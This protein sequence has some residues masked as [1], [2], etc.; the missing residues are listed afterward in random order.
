MDKKLDVV[1]N[2][3]ETTSEIFLHRLYEGLAKDF[4]VTCHYISGNAKKNDYSFSVQKIPKPKSILF[5]LFLILEILQFKKIKSLKESYSKF[6][7]SRFTSNK[8]YFPFISMLKYHELHLCS[9][10]ETK[11]IYTSVRGTDITVT[12]FINEEIISVYKKLTPFI[13]KIHFLSPELKNVTE[14]M[15]IVVKKSAIILQG[16]DLNEFKRKNELPQDSLRLITIGRLHY[17]KGLEFCLLV[18]S[19]L[20]RKGIPFLI[21]IVGNGSEHIKLK[22]ITKHLK[23]EKNVIF[24][25]DLERKELIKIMELSNVYI[26]THWVNGVSNTMLEAIAMNLKVICFDS[27]I[28]S[29]KSESLKAI[30]KEIPRYDLETFSNFLIQIHNSKNYGIGEPEKNN[31]LKL[32]QFKKHVSDFKSFFDFP[33][34]TNY[35]DT[36]HVN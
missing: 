10:K 2:S 7:F 17:I 34:T 18:C 23:L 5:F 22:Y 4:D 31:T 25:G 26:H 36:R 29:Y 13:Y 30:I 20:K 11:K 8:V 24:T 19:I 15:G 16:A 33:N 28:K 12:P 14:K 3:L 6:F 27:N 9:G 21:Y 1:I 35:P 32:F